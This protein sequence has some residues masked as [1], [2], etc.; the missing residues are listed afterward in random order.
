MA[1]DFGTFT[2]NQLGIER[3]K[4]SAAKAAVATK[5]AKVAGIARTIA[6]GSMKEHI[7][8]V[9]SGGAAPIGIIMVDHP[10]ANFVLQGTKPHEIR[11]VRRKML[12]FEVHGK[13]VY[14]RV[15]H[16][17]GTKPN[18]FLLKALIISKGL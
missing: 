12:R 8:V 15:V 16:H 18:N 9:A 5:T 10:A 4:R 1:K 11:P 6:P 14:A 2:P 13:V 7:R 17:P 3:L